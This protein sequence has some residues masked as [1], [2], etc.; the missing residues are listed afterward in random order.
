MAATMSC[1]ARSSEL[2]RRSARAQGGAL[3]LEV[4]IS[5]LIFSIGVLALVGL[6]A[7]M[8]SAQSE[9]KYR[10]DASY[11][12]NEVVGLMWSDLANRGS[13]NAL[14]CA[15]HPRCNDWLEKVTATLP[16]GSGAISIDA[17][18]QEVTITVTWE[19]G[20]EGTRTF[21]TRTRLNE[22]G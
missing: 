4:L 21:T 7:R 17:T 16:N 9:S 22:A 18:S 8:T 19:H 12:A 20:G 6:Q 10:A 13:Y 15:S 2:R 1:P 11:L 14:S 3:L 5:I